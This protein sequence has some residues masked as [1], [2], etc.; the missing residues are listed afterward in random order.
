MTD[1]DQLATEAVQKFKLDPA[2]VIKA[3][4]IAQTRGMIYN[5][6][7]KTGEFDVRSTDGR[8]WYHVAAKSCTCKDSAKGHICK[9]RIAVWLYTQ[10]TARPHAEARRV[11]VAQIMREFGYA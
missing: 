6:K 1:Y 11:P 7:C 3:I 2:R 5:A 9:H 8:S 10:A 4:D